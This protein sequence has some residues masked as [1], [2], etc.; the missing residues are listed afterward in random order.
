MFGK[1]PDR[2]KTDVYIDGAWVTGIDLYSSSYGSPVVLYT[3]S[4]GTSGSH[5]IKIV[6]LNQKNASSTNY[7]SGL[8]YFEYT[9]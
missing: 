5:E 3:Q 7:F 4:W 2:G 8:D 1:G 6:A 9:P